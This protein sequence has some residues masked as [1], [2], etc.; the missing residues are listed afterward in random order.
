MRTSRLG[1]VL[2]GLR[3]SL[4]ADETD[5]EL[6]GRF[7]GG[8]DEAA[9]ERL[10]RRHGPMVLGVCRRVLRHPQDAEDAFQVTFLVLARKADSVH[11]PGAVGGWLHGVAYHT[12]LKAK[13]MNHRRRVRE[14]QAAA[15]GRQESPASTCDDLREVLDREL[16]AMPEHYRLPLIL[17]DLEGRTA[18]DAALQLGLPQGTVAGRLARARDLLAG[19]LARRGVTVSAGVLAAVLGPSATAVVPPALVGS[20]LRAAAGPVSPRIA[21]LADGVLNAMIGSKLKLV[22]S[23]LAAVAILG[24]VLAAAPAPSTTPDPDAPKRAAVFPLPAQVVTFAQAPKVWKERAT[25]ASHKEAVLSVSFGDGI[26]A[27]SSLDETVKIWDAETG[28]ELNSFRPVPKTVEPNDTPCGL[29]WVKFR[30]DGKLL[31]VSSRELGGTV[32]IDF[33]KKPTGGQAVGGVQFGTGPARGVDPELKRWGYADGS[34]ALVEEVDPNFDT[35]EITF[36]AGR[37]PIDGHNGDVNAAAFTPDGTVLAT[38][39]DDKTVKLWDVETSKEIATL[40]GYADGVSCM[41]YSPDG[42]T[43]AAGGKDATVR[44]WDPVSGREK[45][46]LKCGNVPWCLAF[47]PDGTTLAVGSNDNVVEL[48]DPATGKKIAT[49]KGHA[50]PVRSVAFSRDGKLLA[51]ASD[52]K[53]AK[54]WEL[55]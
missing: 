55:Q 8:R 19:R 5:A 22:S 18:K 35:K 11:P 6:V 43:L 7:V 21:A 29:G 37:P 53:T 28:K 31:A 45:A 49:L 10:V 32:L 42:K 47:S 13:A 14:R 1:T 40:T 46:K 41:T 27:T 15:R 50:G 48:W 38:G 3:G 23:A 51:S 2:T 20:T 54:V 39:S 30:P 25:L 34:R 33:S 26:L 52:D 44:L 16:R 9:F 24:G 17:C 36:T 12:A 4:P